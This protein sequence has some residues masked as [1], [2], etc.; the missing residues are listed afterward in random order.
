MCNPI[1][2]YASHEIDILLIIDECTMACCYL[3]LTIRNLRK[4]DYFLYEQ[5]AI[6]TPRFQSE[7]HEQ[8][9]HPNRPKNSQPAK[10]VRVEVIK[11]TISINTAA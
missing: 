4:R 11:K 10:Y 7:N 6:I 2:M 9:S 3:N 8:N 5:L 1:W